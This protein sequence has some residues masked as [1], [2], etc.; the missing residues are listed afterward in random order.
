M[1]I[2]IKLEDGAKVPMRS[3]DG[4]AA[5]DL[6]SGY[7]FPVVI[8]PGQTVVIPT[9]VR[10]QLPKGHYWDLRVRSGLSTKQS[11]FLANGA[12][13]IDEDYRGVVGVPLYNASNEDKRIEAGEKI[14]QAILTKYEFQAFEIV[15]ELEETERGEG[16]FGHTGQ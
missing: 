5:W 13:V 14:A 11:L 12:A 1:L 16:G 7:K 3:T 15:N 4:A 2:K 9:G 10:V 6:F 8:N